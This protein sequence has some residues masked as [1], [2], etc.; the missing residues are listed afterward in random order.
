MNDG[1]VKKGIAEP[2]VSS[3]GVDDIIQFMR[4]GFVRLDDK[5]EMKFYF[6]HKW[7]TYKSLNPTHVNKIMKDKSIH[8]FGGEI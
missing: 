2:E 1:V 8:K 7:N 3:L 5:K 4:F 6:T